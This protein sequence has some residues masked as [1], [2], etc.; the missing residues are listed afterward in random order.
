MVVAASTNLLYLSYNGVQSTNFRPIL[1]TILGNPP[2]I[3]NYNGISGLTMS[4]NR[5][6]YQGEY[7]LGKRDVAGGCVDVSLLKQKDVDDVC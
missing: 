2:N 4:V 7:E 1:D 3:V 5:V 6:S